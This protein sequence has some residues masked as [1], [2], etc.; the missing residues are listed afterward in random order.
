MDRGKAMSRERSGPIGG[1]RDLAF[2]VPDLGQATGFFESFFGAQAVVERGLRED[3]GRSAMRAFANADVRTVVTGSRLLRTPFLNLDLVEARSPARRELWPGMLDVGG[4]H[5]AGYVDDMDA[6]VESLEASDVY[7]LGPGK[8]PTT[9]PPEVGEGSY[10]CHCMTS[11]GFH[12]ELLSYPNGRAYMANYRDR[13][14]NP[15]EPDRGAPPRTSSRAALRGFRGFEHL[16]VSVADIEEVSAFLEQ[17]LGCERFYDMGPMADPHGSGFGA[18]ANVDVRVQASKVRLYRTP[19]LNLELIE[20]TFPGQRR[21]WPNLFDVGGWKIVLSVED[22]DRAL[23]ELRGLD[24]PVHVLGHKRK[25]DGPGTDG[26]QERVSC[27]TSFGLHFD[28]VQGGPLS[29]G[30]PMAHGDPVV[31]G[32][33]VVGWHPGHPDQ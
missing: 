8:K 9:N 27:L 22:V 1:I 11:W 18:Y 2:T 19:Y 29:H 5:L 4:W 13:L 32:G 20:A 21:D 3:P 33:V 28:L 7:I 31:H 15:A 25:E 26:T 6:A 17:A 10:A 23:E 12:F 16:S 24:P 14:W 30:G